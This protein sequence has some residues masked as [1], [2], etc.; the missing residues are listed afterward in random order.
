MRRR[1]RGFETW[2][3]P[4]PAER[5]TPALAREWLVRVYPRLADFAG[6]H[7]ALI[8]GRRAER[9]VVAIGLRSIA[10]DVRRITGA[11][12]EALASRRPVAI[13]FRPPFGRPGRDLPA[14]VRWEARHPH[15]G[16]RGILRRALRAHERLAAGAGD[17]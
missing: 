10:M 16:V 1:A 11:C 12:G 9:E 2:T 17:A 3:L 15:R 8:R 5:L 7:P 6:T 4:P 13:Y 14:V